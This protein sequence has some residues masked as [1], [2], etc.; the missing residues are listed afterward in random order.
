MRDSYPE[1][2]WGAGQIDV[3]DIVTPLWDG[4]PTI[5]LNGRT[6]TI[7]AQ[8]TENSRIYAIATID[9][10]ITAYQIINGL[11][12]RMIPTYFNQLTVKIKQLG[13][14][15]IVIPEEDDL[16]KINVFLVAENDVPFFRKQ[17][18]IK[19]KTLTFDEEARTSFDK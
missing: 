12:S 8:M 2:E 5:E 3:F 6:I 11:N 17:S 4:E 19:S 15:E 7:K 1:F 10:F 14:M 18:D 9:Q 16:R 13:E